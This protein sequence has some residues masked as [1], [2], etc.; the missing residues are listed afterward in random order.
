MVSLGLIA[1][2][3]VSKSSGGR[4]FLPNSYP[5]PLCLFSFPSVPLFHSIY[6]PFTVYI[7]LRYSTVLAVLPMLQVSIGGGYQISMGLVVSNKI[8]PNQFL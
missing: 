4:H 3:T 5:F 7:F 1:I 2:R 8:N 6:T